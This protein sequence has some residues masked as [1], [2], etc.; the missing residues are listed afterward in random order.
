VEQ[1]LTT[2]AAVYPQADTVADAAADADLRAFLAA[3]RMPTRWACARA[4]G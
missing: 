1:P 4:S 2:D 3:G